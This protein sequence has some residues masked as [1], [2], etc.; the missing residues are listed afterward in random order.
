MTI[1]GNKQKTLEI[2]QGG[3]EHRMN[4]DRSQRKMEH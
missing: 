2:T 4:R 3:M 1:S